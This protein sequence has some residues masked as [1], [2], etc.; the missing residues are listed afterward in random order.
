[1]RSNRSTPPPSSAAL[2]LLQ[3]VG[4]FIR[5]PMTEPVGQPVGVF[6]EDHVGVERGCR[7]LETTS[8]MFITG[9]S[10]SIARWTCSPYPLTG[11]L[12]PRAPHRVAIPAPVWV[13][14]DLLEVPAGLIESEHEKEIVH[15]IAEVE[16]VE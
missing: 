4:A 16:D 3:G 1:M 13:E 14:L 8:P 15:V 11:P 10:P 7:P 2:A 9:G 6:V 5:P 12:A